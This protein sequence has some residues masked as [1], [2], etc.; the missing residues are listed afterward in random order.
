MYSLWKLTN[1]KQPV[2]FNMFRIRLPVSRRLA[3][4]EDK[5]TLVFFQC[6]ACL[7]FLSRAP[8]VTLH[9]NWPS[10]HGASKP[11]RLFL[12]LQSNY[13][14]NQSVSCCY[15]RGSWY[16]GKGGSYSLPAEPM[17]LQIMILYKWSFFL[18]PI[19]I[20][21]TGSTSTEEVILHS[22]SCPTIIGVGR[23]L[24]HLQIISGSIDG[25]LDFTPKARVWIIGLERNQEKGS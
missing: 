13:E 22:S 12:T 10:L 17:M 4:L 16:R 24:L 7:A 5:L 23:T 11:G 14:I 21:S 18:L 3:K 1:T 2:N 19:L 6:T 9:V 25:V 20:Y 8:A 15:L